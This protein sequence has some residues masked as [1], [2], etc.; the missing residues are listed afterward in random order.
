MSQN[1]LPRTAKRLADYTAPAF[2]ISHVDLCF[3]L[4][5]EATRDTS[6]MQIKRNQPDALL[7]LDGQQQ[8][9]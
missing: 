3:E 5:A 7:K 8:L 2:N 9:T 4:D 1:S 6:V